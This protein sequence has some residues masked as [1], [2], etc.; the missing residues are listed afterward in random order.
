MEVTA[1]KGIGP[2][3]SKDLKKL[4]ITSISD[5]YNYYPRAYEDRSKLATIN[6]ASFIKKEY[7]IWKII[8]KLFIKNVGKVTVAYLYA[9]EEQ[10]SKR[11]KLL[12]FNDKFTP[13]KLVKGKSYKFFTNIK[14]INDLAE[15]SNPIF[16]ELDEDDIG[17]II[18]IY[19][20]TKGLTSKQISNYINEALKYYDSKE[21]ILSKSLIEKFSFHPRIENLKEVHSPNSITSLSLAKSQIKIVDLLK[22]LCLLD[23]IKK[24]TRNK[25]DITLSYDLDS[26]LEKLSFYLTRSQLVSLNEILEDC[27]SSYSINRLL[28]GDVCSGKTIIAVIVM[29][30][31]AM[32]GYQAA[33]MVPTEILAIQQFEKNLELIKSFNIKLALLTGSSKNKEEIKARLSEGD[34]DILIGTHA[35]IQE[36]VNF[37]NLKFVV[38]DEQHRFGV[39]QRQMLALKGNSV[40]YLTMSAT[41]IP[42]TLSLKISKIIDL[43]VISE[44][45]K[46]R[47]SID[48]ALVGSDKQELLFS[49]LENNLKDGRQVY[50]VTNNIDAEDKNSLVNLM[51]IYKKRFSKFKV[52]MLHGKLKANVKEEILRRF[53]TGEIDLLLSTTVIEV[54]IDVANANII[55][56][57]NA[58]NFGLSTLHQLRGR[59][60]RGEYKSFCY[61]VTDNPSPSS[62]LNILVKTN[63][64]FEIAKKDYDLRGGGRILS[65]IQHGKNLSKIDYLNMDKNDVEKTFRIYEY[66]KKKNFDG[67]N[68]S[69]IEEFYTKDKG[70]ILN[71]WE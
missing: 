57:Y 14:I 10:T 54:G 19:N 24:K 20:L 1:L 66:I 40:N 45:P 12:W 38:N 71:W 28:V 53:Q 23:F 4:G 30:I 69:Y 13:R 32:N 9:I 18:A 15:A 34:I 31:F 52:E 50:I 2:K 16:C 68:L 51:K 35:L 58:G 59:V 25:Q 47:K 46:G 62:K 43:S 61:L 67:V 33:M 64:G 7:F 42:R 26:I 63:D 3:K 65:Y 70:I 8:S 49:N 27:K 5:L 48:T 36:D 22:D 44:L 21:D 56:I 39:S 41:P 17:K 37:K 29:I 6:S 55:V 60:G 11:I